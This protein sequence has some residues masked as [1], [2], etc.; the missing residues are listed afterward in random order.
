MGRLGREA[1]A[2]VSG[3]CRGEPAAG[4]AFWAAWASGFCGV[5]FCFGP[6]AVSGF[7]TGAAAA[8]PGSS[9]FGLGGVVAGIIIGVAGLSGSAGRGGGIGAVA[10][11]S[12]AA[13][14]GAVPSSIAAKTAGKKIRTT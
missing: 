8:G 14:D 13:P 3:F 7:F 11:G 10:T 5:V 12:S 2:V 4:S 9:V 6:A 1:R